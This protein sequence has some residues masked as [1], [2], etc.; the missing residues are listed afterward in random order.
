[1]DAREKKAAYDRVYREANREKIAAYKRDWN[2]ENFAAVAEKK[3]LYREKQGEKRT[4]YERQ[5]RQD[6]AE[7]IAAYKAA[8]KRTKKHLVAEQWN[9]RRARKYAVPVS[10][11][12]YEA[13]LS[14]MTCGICGGEIEGKY[15]FDHII[16]L[17]KGGHHSQDNLQMAHPECNMSKGSKILTKEAIQN[18]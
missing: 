4:E 9:R 6:N 15:H 14:D 11:I 12:D 8:W 13:L 2:R 3:R 1:M 16:P 10:R 5:Y 7:K 18:D 17:A